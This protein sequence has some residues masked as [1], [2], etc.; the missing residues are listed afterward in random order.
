MTTLK[1]RGLISS[2]KATRLAGLCACAAIAHSASAIDLV[3]T[4]LVPADALDKSGL[5]NTIGDR[6]PHNRLG[7]FGSAIDFTGKD[8]LYIAADDRGPGDG[9]T[10]FRPRTQTFRTLIRPE[11]KQPVEVEL[12][13]TTLLTDERGGDLWGYTGGYDPRDQTRGVRF[14]AEGL[15]VSARGTWYI[16]DEYGPWIDEF[17]ST[18]K[19]IRR[20]DVPPIFGVKN[21]GTPEEELP[22]G[23]T[24]GRQPNRG[25]E[26]LALTPDGQTLVAILQS[27]LIQDDALS[28]KNERVGMNIRMLAIDIQSG[29]TRQHVYQLSSAR[30]GVNEILAVSDSTFIVLERDGKEGDKARHRSLYLIDLAGATDVSTVAALPGGALPETIRPV[31]KRELLNFMDP[32]L[33]LLGSQ[34]PEKIEGLTFGPNLFGGRRSLVVTSDN[35]FRIEQPTRV[36]VFAVGATELV[37]ETSGAGGKVPQR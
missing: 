5:T 12:V 23:N 30:N 29:K 32:K 13:A 1:C 2:R 34:M 4:A 15:R 6:I 3:G 7:S 19:R 25:F 17:D 37:F 8:D 31:R 16:S 21:P 33:G 28:D 18:G 26:G 24:A 36:W 20:F 10:A 9:A 14:D 11:S 35:D 27:P 22:P